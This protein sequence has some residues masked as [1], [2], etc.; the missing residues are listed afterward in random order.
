MK[1]TVIGGGLAGCEAAY[2]L[3]RYGI[4]AELWE[5]KPEHYSPAHKY[6]GLA[7]LVCSNS[8]KAS[9]LGSASGL[10]KEEMRLMGSLLVPAAEKT[11]VA[12]GGAL[13]VD[14]ELFSAAVTRAVSENPRIRLHREEVDTLSFGCP[15]VVA[16]GPLTSDKMAEAIGRLTGEES[17]DNFDSFVETLNG[18]GLERVL[19]I[20]Q[21]AYDRFLAR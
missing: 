14:R 12:A 5:Q 21:A 1:A 4:E 9:R 13:A 2:T 3:A 15:A 11:A 19:E 8:L 18:M 17:L 20:Q 10:L 16:T 7:E 6:P